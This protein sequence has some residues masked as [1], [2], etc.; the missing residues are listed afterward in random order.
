M[1]KARPRFTRTGRTYMPEKYRAWRH[2][3]EDLLKGH[4]LA[5]DLPTISSCSAAFSFYGPARFDLDNL[6]GAV[7]DAGLPNKATGWRGCWRDDRV[8]VFP[9]IC[10]RW[11]RSRDQRIELLISVWDYCET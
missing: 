8:S 2:E 10:A 5:F 9:E 7:L 6:V 11:H 4:W 3:C 1:S